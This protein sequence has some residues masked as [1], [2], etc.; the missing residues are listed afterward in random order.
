[1]ILITYD[2]FLFSIHKKQ[3]QGKCNLIVIYV[4]CWKTV[5]SLEKFHG[6]EWVRSS[7]Q[8]FIWKWINFL[9]SVLFM[10]LILFSYTLIFPLSVTLLDFHTHCFQLVCGTTLAWLA[11]AFS[12]FSPFLSIVKTTSV[13]SIHSFLKITERTFWNLLSLIKGRL[14]TMDWIFCLFVF[15]W[16]K[17]K[18]N[19]RLLCL[20]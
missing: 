2:A 19:L 20:M 1:M 18:I 17:R 12:P 9:W 6:W 8:Y 14:K 4:V 13:D 3:S 16:I 15:F 7:W 11:L 5:Y 10:I